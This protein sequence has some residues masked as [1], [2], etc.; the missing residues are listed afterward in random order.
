MLGTKRGI[1][2]Q[3]FLI[4][5]YRCTHQ[6]WLINRN[7]HSS[8]LHGHWMSSRGLAKSD[9]IR[10]RWWKR[11]KGI[12]AISMPWWGGKHNYNRLFV[13][14]TSLITFWWVVLSKTQ[15]CIRTIPSLLTRHICYLFLFPKLIIH[16][17]GMIWRH[18]GHWKKYNG[19]ISQ[20]IK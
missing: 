18:R 13:S 15:D 20:S 12:C 19:T 5:S 8:V 4:D 3:H 10:D 2:K 1:H 16:L 9:S 11:F 17:N 7:L 14:V 6:C